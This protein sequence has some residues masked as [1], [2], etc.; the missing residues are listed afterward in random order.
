MKFD[1]LPLGVSFE[2][3]ARQNDEGLFGYMSKPLIQSLAELFAGKKVVEAYAGRG[4]LTSLLREQGVD[5]R[6]TS[7]RMGHD[8]T[9][10]LG[11]FCE[12][13]D[14][15]VRDAVSAYGHDL[16]Y[17]LVCWPVA[18]ASLFH[19]AG[20]LSENTKIVFIGEV[21]DYTTTPPFLGGCATDEFFDSVVECEELAALL[22]YPTPRQ[23]K[24]KVY[25]AR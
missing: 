19:V 2:H 6:A 18:D 3:A 16:D 15:S 17:L 25:Q 20:R 12:V 22:S 13:E 7:L 24:I 1:D 8:R 11:H 14:M 10:T 9:E 4:L 5:I 23:D 21:T